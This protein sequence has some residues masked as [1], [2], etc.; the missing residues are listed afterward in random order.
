[1][2]E[3]LD[4]EG[5][6]FNPEPRLRVVP[7]PH[8]GRCVVA[9]DALANPEGVRQ[10]AAKQA[11]QP[12][13]FPYPGLVLDAPTAMAEGMAEFFAQHA[14]AP[15]GGRRTL[16]HGTRLSVLSTPPEAL[17]PLLWQCHRDRV[18]AGPHFL[19][20]ASVL[21]LFDQPALGGTSFYRPLRD[22]AAID[23]M[24]ADSEVMDAA[25]FS[26][27]H[28]VQPGYMTDSNSHF[29][30][31]ARVLAAWNRAIFY[32]GELFHAP[33]V[34][35]P[36]RINADVLRGRLTLNGFYTCKRAAV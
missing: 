16:Q 18:S 17:K 7:L 11:F 30:R 33:D 32:D 29:E 3:W 5:R 2:A 15:L 26:A 4:A 10:W 25:T 23:R 31:V 27:R 6:F 35:E 28:G 19:F 14:R 8:G 34:D 1:M 20:A 13:N 21:Y 9:D 12:P 24:L 36:A 22:P